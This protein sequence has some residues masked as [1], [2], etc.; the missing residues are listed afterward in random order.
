MNVYRLSRWFVLTA[1]L[2]VGTTALS[3]QVAQ[4]S[5]A[6][7]NGVEVLTRG[8]VHEAFAE[9]ITFDPE[10]GIVVPKAPPDRS[11]KWRLTRGRKVPTS[12]GFPATGVGTTSG[13]ISCGS[14]EFGAPCRPVA[15]GCPAIGVNRSK[16]F[17]GLPATGPMQRPTRL[18]ICP[19]RRR[20]SRRVPTLP[21]LPRTTLG[22][23]AVGFGSR[24]AT[25]GAPVTGRKGIKI[26]I[27]CPTIT[28]GHPAATSS[29]TVTTTT[30]FRVAASCLRPSIS[31]RV[32]APSAVSPTHLRR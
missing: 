15:S 14:A 3:Q 32:S 17:N 6:G 28:C 5:A 16:A 20:R 10:P 7:Q 22:C 30:R 12:P 9:T 18:T 25:P 23:Q 26:G 19:S 1:L 4:Q 29:S 2:A 24:T 31:I 11:K 8:P 27:G 13:T 21:R